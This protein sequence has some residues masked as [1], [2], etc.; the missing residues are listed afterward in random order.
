MHRA[1]SEISPIFSDPEYSV[2]VLLGGDFNIS[3]RA[4]G[5][6]GSGSEQDRSRSD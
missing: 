5:P 4:R 6:F 3:T 2:L 1:L